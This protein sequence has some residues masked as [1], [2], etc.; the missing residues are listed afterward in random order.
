MTFGQEYS[1]SSDKETTS[2][3]D[4]G[5]SNNPYQEL[6]IKK[7]TWEKIIEDVKLE[8]VNCILEN[9]QSKANMQ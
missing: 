7:L 6:F 2:F 1:N 4:T 3:Y 8:H 5:N 9:Y